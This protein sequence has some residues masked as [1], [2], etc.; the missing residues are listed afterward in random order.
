MLW[1]PNRLLAVLCCAPVFAPPLAHAQF[2]V[3]DVA[4]VNQLLQQVRTL[5]QQLQ[6]AQTQVTQAQMLYQST[7]GNRGMAQ[8]LN[9]VTRNYLPSNWPQLTAA[10]QGAG[11]PGSLGPAIQAAT[12]SNAVLSNSQLATVSI[13]EQSQIAAAR[14]S[15]AL[16]QALTQQ[17]LVNSSGR[18]ADIR[19][20]IDAIGS[21]R[22]Q[23]GILELQARIGAEQ[24]M[25]QNEHTKLQ[26]LYQAA[27]AQ[28]A[29]LAEQMREQGVAANGDF[30]SRFRPTAP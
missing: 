26:V 23:K 2:A 29:V 5:Q 15:A 20:L 19:Q 3:I 17:A 27:Q 13:A 24:D 16:L 11:A 25:L 10:M 12:A 9:G 4:A 14:G 6:A 7:T 22:D 1:K 8:L 28:A 30:A 18:F 21:A